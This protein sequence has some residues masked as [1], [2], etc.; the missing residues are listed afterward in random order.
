MST[1]LLDPGDP[2]ASNSELI[3]NALEV[4]SE[5]RHGLETEEGVL[6]VV[7]DT[8]PE[9]LDASFEYLQEI[10]ESLRDRL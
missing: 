1:A 10:L 2:L 9:W 8:D 7:I 5:L 4:L 3:A 6:P